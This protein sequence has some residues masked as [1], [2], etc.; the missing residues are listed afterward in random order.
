MFGL[1]LKILVLDDDDDDCFLICETISEI[2]GG[3]YEVMTASNPKAAMELI[4]ENA[5]HAVLC[6]YRL[7]A[8]SGARSRKRARSDQPHTVPRPDRATRRPGTSLPVLRQAPEREP[9]L[10]SPRG[11]APVYGHRKY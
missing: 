10:P 4:R 2:E 7:G 1:G 6:D 3:S 5:F 11:D 8:T 9:A